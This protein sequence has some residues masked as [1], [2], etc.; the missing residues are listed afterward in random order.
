MAE[1][2]HFDYQEGSLYAQVTATPVA[3]LDRSRYLLL[4]WND[5]PSP[6]EESVDVEEKPLIKAEEVIDVGGQ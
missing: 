3:L 5:S 2:S 1:V 6:E 4:L